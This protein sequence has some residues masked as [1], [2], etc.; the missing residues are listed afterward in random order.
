MQL[1]SEKINNPFKPNLIDKLPLLASAGLTTFKSKI[2]KKLKSRKASQFQSNN[3]FKSNSNK[4]KLNWKL[5]ITSALSV[6]CLLGNTADVGAYT[7]LNNGGFSSKNSIVHPTLDRV[8]TGFVDSKLST[9]NDAE[10][11]ILEHLRTSDDCANRIVQPVNI[12]KVYASTNYDYNNKIPNLTTNFSKP[13]DFVALA[14]DLPYIANSAWLSKLS[15]ISETYSNKF[16][17]DSENT[18]KL[19]NPNS[20]LFKTL[21][22]YQNKPVNGLKILSEYL[23]VNNVSSNIA[24]SIIENYEKWGVLNHDID[25]NKLKPSEFTAIM[26]GLGVG[27]DG[28]KNTSETALNKARKVENIASSVFQNDTRNKQVLES[29]ISYLPEFQKIKSIVIKKEL[30]P[31]YLLALSFIINYCIS[32]L[33]K[34]IKLARL[35]HGVDQYNADFRSTLNGSLAERIIFFRSKGVDFNN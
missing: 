4:L 13:S 8:L 30:I 31:W 33:I 23:K 16:I 28:G 9:S 2:G 10:Q 3:E 12:T 24:T 15:S 19:L 7:D 35:N 11:I 17:F 25:V 22:K 5:F 32:E 21:E 20:K 27:L 6:L 26:S 34:K 18:L 14:C 1:S 29:D